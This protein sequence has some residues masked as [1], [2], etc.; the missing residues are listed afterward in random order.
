[1]NGSA[2]DQLAGGLVVS[3]QAPPGSP[4]RR[5]DV[6]AAMAQ[7]AEQAGAV[8]IRAEGAADIMAVRAACSLPIIGIRKRFGGT[9]DVFITATM[10]DVTEVV[11]A[12]AD[13]V[14]VDGTLRPRPDGLS[15]A[16]FLDQVVAV[17]IPVMADVDNAAAATAAADRGVHLIA[18][19]LA[20]YT[21]R[22]SPGPTTPDIDLV[23]SIRSA[24]P[25]A[26]IVAEG[27]YSTPDDLAA[28]FAAGAYAV[29]V[30]TAIT[31]TLDLARRFARATP[32]MQTATERG[33]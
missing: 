5:P 3:C 4:L 25:D 12:G 9:S 27:R 33:Q 10:T 14:A 32:R 1:M 6:M 28:A 23:A 19:T 22:E 15:T 20:G 11:E 13:V 8:G 30:G 17:G 26:L 24:L 18:T 16:A 29:V 21:D 2:L 31:D 7:A